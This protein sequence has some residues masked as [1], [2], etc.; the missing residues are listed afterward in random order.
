MA[1]S[2][3]HPGDPKG[4]EAYWGT[5]GPGAIKIR[6]GEKGDLA[7]C[8]LYLG[9]YFPDAKDR[10]SALQAKAMPP[11]SNQPGYAGAAWHSVGD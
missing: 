1:T 5:K 4:M 10:C 8:I 2:D 3:T 7:R 9:K 6:W 11:V